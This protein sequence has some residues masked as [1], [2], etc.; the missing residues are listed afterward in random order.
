ML[1]QRFKFSSNDIRLVRRKVST[2]THKWSDTDLYDFK[3]RIKNHLLLRQKKCCYCGTTFHNLHRMNIDIEH[4]IPVSKWRNYMFKMRN[5][6][7]ACKRCNLAIKGDDTSFLVADSNLLP[8]RKF[9]SSFY[10]FIHP[11]LDIYKNHLH[12]H[13]QQE[14]DYLLI[15]YT[16][17]NESSKGKFTYN[18]FKLDRLEINTFDKAQGLDTRTEIQNK[19]INDEFN[20]LQLSL[21]F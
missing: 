21:E 11:N 3:R 10:K 9:K 19:E 4:I 20:Q 8:K 17:V 12:L 6:S 5:L 16:V 7:L 13:I 15:K 14:N 2:L 18:Y 1:M